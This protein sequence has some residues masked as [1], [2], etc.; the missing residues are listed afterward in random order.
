MKKFAFL[1]VL[2]L[3]VGAAWYVLRGPGDAEE[4]EAEPATEVAVHVG[5]ITRATLRG[6]VTAYGVVQPEPAGQNPAASANV[7]PFLP[8]VVAAV[9]AVEGQRVA[10][11]D[12]LFRLDSRAAD[13][14]VDFAD[15][16][17]QRERALLEIDG[18][19][20]RAVQDAEQQLDAARV[21]Q[22]FAQVQAPL[23]GTVARVYVKPG[24]AVDVTSIMAEV[25][26]LNR[27]VVS[28]SVPSAELGDLEL[29][30]PVQ[31]TADRAAASVHGTLSFISPQ[32]D[33][34]TGTAE[35]RVTLPADSRLRPGQFVTIRIV[36]EEHRDVLAVPVE[37]VTRDEEGAT[38]VAVVEGDV[39]TQTV[40]D[41]GLRDA[42]LVEI[43]GDGVRADM[44]VVT[45]GAY[46]LPAETQV[47]VI[48]D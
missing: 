11:G 34:Q 8:G 18:T 13:V 47:R 38:V 4:V 6:Y 37:S 26:D 17:L 25:V 45:E 29:G 27:L 15:R 23:T 39:A 10:K 9:L 12:I 44:T 46:G 14:A 36:S 42:G 5:T 48:E 19:S 21:Q 3:L 1:L 20:Q 28:A 40:V 41:T 24:E 33:V 43:S 32:V 22:A 2:V 16:T 30:Q 35:V 7:A 31:V